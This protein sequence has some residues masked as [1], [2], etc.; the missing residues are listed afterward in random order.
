MTC[1]GSSTGGSGFVIVPPE[2]TFNMVK[3]VFQATQEPCVA[4]DCHGLHTENILELAI[5]CRLHNTLLTHM[6]AACGNIPVVT[7]GD[8]TRSALVHLLKGPCGET[9][10]M[11]R[12]CV[13]DEFGTTCVPPEYIAA[14]EQWI[15]MGAPQ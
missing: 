7:P 13:E 5:D 2:P 10:R 4:S 9:P 12:D 6:S 14:I 11:P 8:P 3:F 1:A 15:T